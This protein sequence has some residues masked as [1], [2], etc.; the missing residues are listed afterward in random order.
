[1]WR[2]RRGKVILLYLIRTKDDRLPQSRRLS[3]C[4][5][6]KGSHHCAATDLFR[7]VVRRRTHERESLD[8]AVSS[9]NAAKA[10]WAGVGLDAEGHC[11][12][13]YRTSYL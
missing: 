5:P 2:R 3:I 7:A 9:L 8:R 11:H 6:D 4:F 10:G 13:E 12:Y 1:M